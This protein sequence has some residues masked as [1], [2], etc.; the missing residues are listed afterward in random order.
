MINLINGHKA[1]KIHLDFVKISLDTIYVKIN[2]SMFLTQQMG[3]TGADE[4]MS[5]TTFS[6]TELKG[7]K[8]VDYDFEEGDHANPGT[9]SRQDYLERNK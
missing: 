4:Y 2:N 5:V 8:Y 3:T 1:N 9:Y 6:L 7:I